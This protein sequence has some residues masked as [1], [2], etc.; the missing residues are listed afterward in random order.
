MCENME[1][2]CK[3]NVSYRLFGLPAR[4]K[5]VSTNHQQ[6]PEVLQQRL[7][8]TMETSIIPPKHLIAFCKRPTRVIYRNI[9]N[10]KN[11]KLQKIQIS[12]KIRIIQFIPNTKQ[13]FVFPIFRKTQKFE[14]ILA[15]LVFL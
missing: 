5:K 13:K 6:W 3:N 2:H 8:E 15:F 10:P 9:K 12:P 11:P 1:V 4:T 7:Q 14:R